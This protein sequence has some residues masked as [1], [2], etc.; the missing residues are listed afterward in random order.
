M[1]RASELEIYKMSY[2]L[3]RE[4]HKIKSK[5]P[6]NLKYDIGEEL[7]K[8]AMLVLRYIIQA[9]RE[10]D[11][12]NLLK[13]LLTEC[14]LLWSWLRLAYDLKGMTTG[15]FR[16]LSERLEDLSRQGAAWT[17]W[18]KKQNGTKG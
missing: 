10:T 6:R 2:L 5:M 14:E 15:E 7:M 1:K 17:K 8:S 4:I 12:R 18:S 9:S 16:L 3:T 13:D 11:K